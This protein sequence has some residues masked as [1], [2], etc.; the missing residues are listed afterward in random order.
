MKEWLW[1]LVGAS[2]EIRK[3]R[4]KVEYQERWIFARMNAPK[5]KNPE[6]D[7][8]RVMQRRAGRLMDAH[9]DIYKQFLGKDALK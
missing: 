2:E 7:A 4:Q 8:L 9:P 3:L 5:A 6:K 1:K